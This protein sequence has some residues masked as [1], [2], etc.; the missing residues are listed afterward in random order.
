M[1]LLRDRHRDRQRQRKIQSYICIQT[2]TERKKSEYQKTKTKHL[3]DILYWKRELVIKG[4]HKVSGTRCPVWSD[5]FKKSP[6]GNMESAIPIA[7]LCM[8]LNWS[9]RS[10]VDYRKLSLCVLQDIRANAP[11]EG[12]GEQNLRETL[13]SYIQKGGNWLKKKAQKVLRT[14]KRSFI[15]IKIFLSHYLLLLFFSF[16]AAAPRADNL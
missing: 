15:W 4:S 3:K 7:L 14:E 11:K 8:I 9:N 6:K 2:E 13:N 16:W 12:E 10:P 1:L 5:Q